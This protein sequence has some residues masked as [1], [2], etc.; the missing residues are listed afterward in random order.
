VRE[1]KKERERYCEAVKV[2]V[3]SREKSESLSYLW[4]GAS[5]QIIYSK[6]L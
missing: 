3:V 1:R 6:L 2:Y 4:L 5:V